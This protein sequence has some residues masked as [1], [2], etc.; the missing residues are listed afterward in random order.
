[1]K[2]TEE[3]RKYRGWL[4]E[5]KYNC[6]YHFTMSKETKVIRTNEAKKFIDCYDMIDEIEDKASQEK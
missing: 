5:R 4:I 3:T 1:M 6:K 2:R